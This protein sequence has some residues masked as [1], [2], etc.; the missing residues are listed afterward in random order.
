MIEHKIPPAKKQTTN[1]QG[2]LHA[3]M[4]SCRQNLVRAQW[5]IIGV[6]VLVLI[7]GANWSLSILQAAMHHRP[8]IVGLT[9][10][11]ETRILPATW[12][13]LRP[14][15]M[16]Y[17]VKR[18]L[19]T[20]AA[21]FYSRIPSGVFEYDRSRQFVS[22]ELAAVSP[23]AKKIAHEQIKAVSE[24]QQDAVVF[25]VTNVAFEN[26]EQIAKS[27]CP[28]TPDHRCV[29]VIRGEKAIIGRGGQLPAQTTG[30]LVRVVFII[31]TDVPASIVDDNPLGIVIT[32]IQVSEDVK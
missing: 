29:A 17:V 2:S 16:L 15:D 4:E 9:A 6:F 1:P 14:K 7:F 26:E 25:A 23:E 31:K 19:K 12:V 24:G 10:E 22:M 30:V 28:E 21:D 11:G 20:W 32:N 13:E 5:V 18:D 3:A 8:I 27:R